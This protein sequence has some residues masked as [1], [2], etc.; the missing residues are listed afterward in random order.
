ML[1]TAVHACLYTNFIP[2][3]SVKVR[4]SAGE[5]EVSE[6]LAMASKRGPH[7]NVCTRTTATLES[8]VHTHTPAL[9]CFKTSQRSDDRT[10][11]RT[12]GSSLVEKHPLACLE[13]E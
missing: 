3:L 7:T 2:S 4:V 9:L 5:R 13:G 6:K 12:N 1:C 11:G 10:D 8:K